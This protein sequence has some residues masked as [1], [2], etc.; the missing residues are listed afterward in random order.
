MKR[1]V[2]KKKKNSGGATITDQSLPAAPRGREERPRHVHEAWK[3]KELQ[4]NKLILPQRCDHIAGVEHN[5]AR[6][7]PK[8]ENPHSTT[9]IGCYYGLKTW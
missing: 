2:Q 5:K 4:G 3:I 7:R 1:I 9:N 6:N 8:L